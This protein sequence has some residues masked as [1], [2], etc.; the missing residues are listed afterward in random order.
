MSW[1]ELKANTAKSLGVPEQE[2]EEPGKE[3][4]GDF[5][6]PAFSKA[7][8]ERK[9]PVE[10]AKSI[11][12]KLRVKGIKEIK[13]AGP[14]VNFFVDWGLLGNELLKGIDKGY[15]SAKDKETVI[16]DIFQANPYKSFHIG[17]VRN[18][19]FGEAVRKILEKRGKKTIPVSFNGDVGTHIAK[20]LW[21]YQKFYK[22]EVP[23]ENFT[24]W[25]GE[26]Y[27]N[28][29]KKSEEK[30]EYKEQVAELNRKLDSREKSILPLWKKFRDMCMDDLKNIA[31]E[32]DVKVERFFLESECEEP[33]KKLVLKL[34]SE[35]KLEKSEGAIVLNLEKHG[36]GVFLLLKNDG[37]ALYS[38]KDIGLLQ[39]KRKEFKFDRMIYVVGS[40][41]NLYFRQL[42]KTFDLLGIYPA[43]KSLHMSYGMVDLKEGKMSSRLGNVITYEDLRDETIK[44]VLEKIQEKNPELKNKGE[45][46]KKIALGAIKFEMLAVENNRPIKF[47]WEQALNF[48]ARSGPYLQYTSTRANS[49]LKKAGG[50]KELKSD[51][52]LLTEE[53]EIRLLKFLAKYPQV[54]EKAARDYSPSTL[55]NFLL[56]LGDAFNGFYQN[57]PV[58][59]AKT[60][61]EKDARLKLVQ[62]VKQVLD[63]GLNLLGIETLDEM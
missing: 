42:F 53:H 4:F 57:V 49:I 59:K 30:E 40:E 5:A 39:L 15:G 7:K 43:E 46:A 35:G 6:W 41:Q 20:W 36:L 44:Q 54:L 29:C 47:D 9:N 48:E 33:G 16:M 45:T 17:H 60:A 24:R 14:Y 22:G 2:I 27:A 13:A 56:E 62:A 51:A 50:G 61:G 63:D 38:T 3:G 8:S 32:L 31:K 52:R 58:I 11:S 34:F 1:S 19:A 12:G 26:M 10:I 25:A 21:Y 18:A 55:S 28:A 37:T 23:K